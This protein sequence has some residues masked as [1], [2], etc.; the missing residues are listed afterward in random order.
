MKNIKRS[1]LTFACISF[2]VLTAYSQSTE[3]T[4]QG[5]L[6][7]GANPANGN[8]DFEFALYDALSG[9]TQLGSTLARNG[10]AVVKGVFSVS[11]DFGSQF[12]G[13]NRFLEIH[14]RPSGGGSFTNLTPRQKI[15][16][17][18]YAIK[19]VN[20]DSAVNATNAVSAAN[21]ATATNALNLGG[22]A[23]NQFVLTGDVRLNDARN[24]LPGSG[25]YIQNQNAAPQASSNFNI[26]GTGAANLFDVGTQYNLGGVRILSSQ[27]N[28][29]LF[30]G[31]DA[32]ASNTGSQNVF[33]GSSAGLSNGSGSDNVFVGRTAGFSNMTGADNAFFG[34]GAGA[35]NV[36]GV[37][38][39]FFGR[40]AGAANTASNNSFFG[41]FSGRLTT[42]GTENSFF[43]QQAGVSN[44]TGNNNTFVGSNAGSTNVLGSNNTIVGRNANVSGTN[45]INASAF[46]AN[47]LVGQ[48]NSLVLGSIL[49]VNGATENT[50]VG[51]GTSQPNER[52]HV[53]GNALIS[54]DLTFGGSFNGSVGANR[55][56]GIVS[57]GQG[58]T[59]LN[60][61]GT[62]GNF[63]RSTGTA[64]TSA[65][66]TIV[67]IPAGNANYIQ[68][69]NA[70]PQSANLNI[71]G[72]ATIGGYGAVSLTFSA[73]TVNSATQYN[74]E[75][76]RVLSV[77]GISN[78]FVGLDAGIANTTGQQNSFFGRAAGAA[79]SG[80]HFNSFFGSEAGASNTTGQSNSFFG[81]LAGSV[82]NGSDN[83]FFGRSAGAANTGSDNSFFGRSAGIANT[84]GNYNSFFGVS[85]GSANTIGDSNSFFG[86]SAGNSNT[87]GF[88]NSFFGLQAGS[89]NTTGHNNTMIGQ[90]SNVASGDLSYA[91]AIGAG[92]SVSTSN[93]VMLGGGLATV[94][95]NALGGSTATNLCVNTASQNLLSFCSSSLRYKENV[96][97]FNSGIDLVGRLRPVTFDWKER[98]E[99]DLGLIAEEVAE[100]EPLLV[101]HNQKGE[102]EGV[103][104]DQIS[105]VLINAVKEQQA[106]IERQQM[107]IEKQQKQIEA[108]SAL[109]CSQIPGTGV[110]R[111]K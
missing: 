58:G 3:F 8:Y 78:T 93:T 75:G 74:I 76:N 11:L 22:V 85:A 99:S 103:K 89:S 102:I 50:N 17:E 1:L 71:S 90:G 15:T 44:S 96:K 30:V 2:L 98:K 20:A 87:T 101:T 105:V 60:S 70:A 13:T 65:P 36:G 79:N 18:P 49:G 16:S 12:P 53:V 57:P 73:G 35:L 26:S 46:G 10:L 61:V 59:G 109:V 28:Q 25:S 94:R 66:L 38:N 14:V 40:R 55:I 83:S 19:A 88:S 5:D 111:K 64:W 48:S 104:Y 82:N 91:T 80:G 37:N 21:S 41:Y 100:I 23:A 106:Q 84:T 67:D 68:N 69:Q 77:A 4:Y 43:G 54:G 42:G 52:L 33:V 62:A 110:C 29:N 7:D 47:A 63:L 31:A 92:A 9:G 34:S 24:P 81:S 95:I 97:S 86:I 51:I 107:L 6:K 108:L 72:N 39:S 45:A 56:T 27:G 32:G